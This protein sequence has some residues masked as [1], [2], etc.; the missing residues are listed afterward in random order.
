MFFFFRISVDSAINTSSSMAVSDLDY[1][2][3]LINQLVETSK[4]NPPLTVAKL[5]K[6]ASGRKLN[7]RSLKLNGLGEESFRGQLKRTTT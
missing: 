4:V 7:I 6:K 3:I 5:T 1:I 2:A